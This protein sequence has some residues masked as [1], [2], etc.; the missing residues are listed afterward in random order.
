M[1]I[2]LNGSTGITEANIAD[3]AITAN[4][5]ASD[6]VTTAKIATG[7]VGA[8]DIADGAVLASK[9]A[10]GKYVRQMKHVRLDSQWTTTSNGD[11]TA[12][13]LN[14]DNPVTSGNQI[15]IMASGTIVAG[16]NYDNWGAG[17]DIWLNETRLSSAFNSTGDGGVYMGAT[18]NNSDGGW[19][20]NFSL[21]GI[22]TAGSTNPTVS[23]RANRLPNNGGWQWVGFGYTSQYYGKTATN[24]V[25][26]EFGA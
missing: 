24:L 12:L 17:C 15:L 23:L 4:K 3:S 20:M 25:A 18:D 11:V 7:A 22:G 13:S 21:V 1:A 14:F 10:I 19:G 26:I 6:A 2:T 5:I 8:A 9:L 16:T